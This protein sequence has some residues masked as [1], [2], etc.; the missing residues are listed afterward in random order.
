MKQTRIYKPGTRQVDPQPRTDGE[1]HSGQSRNGTG[2]ASGEGE[3][4]PFP[5][6][7]LPE[8]V[9]DMARAIADTERTPASLAGVCTLGF[10]SAAIGKGLDVQ[11]G[12]DRRTRGN[13]YLLAS[14]ESGSGK[15][16]SFRHAAKPFNEFEGDLLEAWRASTLPG[17]AAEKDIL[18]AEIGKLKK[19]AG[20]AEGADERGEIK[21]KLEAKKAALAEIEAQLHAPAFTVEDVTTEKLAALLAANGETLASIS[22]DAGA[23]VNNLLGRYSSLDRTDE[24]VYLKA[25]SGDFLRVD[26]QKHAEPILLK[27]PCLAALWLTQPDKLET[28]LGEKELT[29]GGL[30]PRL[31]VCHTSAEALEIVEGATGIPAEVSGAYRRTIRDL[32]KAYRL[33]DEPRTIQ[34]SPDALALLNRHF[35]A[36]VARRR[37]ELRDVT[38][39]AARWNE[40]AW[41]LA[42]CLH[43]GEWGA[44]AHGQALEAETAARA[45]ELAD[46]FAAQQL[47]ILSAGRDAGRRKVRD[48]V[49]SLLAD[50]PAGITARD[51]QRA[52]ITR[53]ADEAHALLATMEGEGTL[54]GADSQPEGG[55]HVT[56]TFTRAR[57]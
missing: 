36:I 48:E 28:L 21:A 57:Q 53:T 15:S 45:I 3:A 2:H 52:G 26:R 8:S 13:V 55:G 35:N 54:A 9:G 34:P 1:A 56:R 6:H 40:Q 24:S 38:S 30:I 22:P 14:A 46:W 10:L 50:K 39:Y 12:P 37:V 4:K 18:E 33:A 29:D 32:L 49:L 43:A 31:L 20:N 25:F 17:L 11:S 7:C 41:R 47:E 23:I 42:V 27:S 44:Q 19:E 5:L 16:E 51:V